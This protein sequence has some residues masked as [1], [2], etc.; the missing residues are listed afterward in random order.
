MK[1]I[2]L[3]LLCVLPALLSAQSQAPTQS[4]SQAPPLV[5]TH[6]TVIDATGAPARPDMT[7]VI[8]NDRITELGKAGKV[9]IPKEAQVVDAKGKFLIPGLWDMHVHTSNDDFLAMYVANGVTGV[10]DMF[11]P[12]ERINGWRAQ[13]KEGKL[14]GPRFV[15]AGPIVDGPKPVW[16]GSIAVG[17][18]E[19]GRQAVSKVK[20][21]GSDFVKV[22]S[23][24]PRD[25]FFAIAEEAKKQGIPF[26]GHVPERV[27]AAEASDAGQKSIEHL[28]GVLLACSRDEDAIRAEM[29]K[30]IAASGSSPA[31]RTARTAANLKAVQSYDPAKAAALFAR[32]K[33]N[34]TWQSPTLIVLRAVA[35]LNDP[36]F[37]NDPR[38]KYMRAPMRNFW[39][40]QNDFRFKNRTAEDWD[41]ARK[42]YAKYLEVTGAMRKA[43]VEFIAGTDVSNPYCFPGFS[44]HDEL[45]LLVKTGFTPMEALQAATLN[46]AKYL[47]L[48][49][50]LGTVEKGKIAN[51]VLLD[52]NPLA[53]IGNT[54]KINAVIVG[55][56]LITK[57]EIEAMLAKV[58]AAANQK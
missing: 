25:A 48:L 44:L 2:A 21:D 41:N 15:A 47:G 7:V 36:N 5:F 53:E 3:F 22:Y 26:A 1:K 52:A 49:D 30:V 23:L 9:R 50:S 14:L 24:L 58:E 8:A 18:A 28:T 11:T 17:N 43:G 42:V 51:L 46:P 4:Q 10:R 20:A 13:I 39:N 57:S 56:K 33:K 27:S 54:Q 19:E 34:G 55:G 32:F 31:S 29:D 37:T 45:A 6:V 38:L 35:H 12:L 40:P 16:Q